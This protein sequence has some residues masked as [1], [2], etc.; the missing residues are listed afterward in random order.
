MEET[1]ITITITNRRYS[2][3]ILKEDETLVKKA[4]SNL[5]KKVKYYADSFEYKDHQDLFAMISLDCLT[6]ELHRTVTKSN[7]IIEV[8]YDSVF[9]SYSFLDR[10]FANS[11]N[12]ILKELGVRTFLFEKD[13]PGG[14]ELDKI[15][16]DGIHENDR[17]L[18][19]SSENSI[20]SAACQYELSEARHK[21]NKLWENIFFPIHIDNFLFSVIKSQ[22]RP[23]EKAE[24]YWK[25][26]NS[27]KKIN[28]LDF[29]S[30]NTPNPDK[31]K[32]F[33]NAQKLADQLRKE[34]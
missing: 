17:L 31:D 20:K 23:R 15:M 30:F 1:N 29:S 3:K 14:K 10:F 28:S 16:I 34:F 18:F 33:K 21:E 11:L 13:A 12:E 2:L 24:E 19:I 22:I 6:Q 9:I 27:L 7:S 26:I 32:F 4:V 8:C 25:N 5:Q